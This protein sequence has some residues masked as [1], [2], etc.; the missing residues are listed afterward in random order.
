MSDARASL[1]A[2]EA[3][4]KGGTNPESLSTE[5]AGGGPKCNQC[6][7]PMV[8]HFDRRNVYRGCDYALEHSHEPVELIK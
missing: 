1:L 2:A 3:G 7:V 6:T 8:L 4:D 5:I